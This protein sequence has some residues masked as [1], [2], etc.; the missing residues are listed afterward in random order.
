VIVSTGTVYGWLQG[1]GE[2]SLSA[3]SQELIGAL[4]RSPCA[5]VEVP[6]RIKAGDD[7]ARWLEQVHVYE[8]L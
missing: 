1:L 4:E 7:A 8:V 5:V 6:R 2:G 3:P